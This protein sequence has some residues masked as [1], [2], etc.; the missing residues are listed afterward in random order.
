MVIG[1]PANKA[2]VTEVFLKHNQKQYSMDVIVRFTL[3]PL[4]PVAQTA[5]FFLYKGVGLRPLACWD[6]GFESRH[7]GMD[8]FLLWVL[9]VIR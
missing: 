8:D 2:Y 6:C 7:G 9:C 1:H 3:R 5:V 4:L